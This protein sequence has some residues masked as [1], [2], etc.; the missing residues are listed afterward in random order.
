M[1]LRISGTCLVLASVPLVWRPAEAVPISFGG[2]GNALASG[3]SSV[4]GFL[5]PFS[6]DYPAPGNQDFI[7]LNQD[8]EEGDRGRNIAGEEMISNVTGS[9]GVANGQAAQEIT[10]AD[11][12]FY[13][14]LLSNTKR[15]I[16]ALENGTMVEN[17][18]Q[19]VAEAENAL[20]NLDEMPLFCPNVTKGT[21]RRVCS[22]LIDFHRSFREF[23]RADLQVP[24][25]QLD[26]IVEFQLIVAMRTLASSLAD[27]ETT[28]EEHQRNE[29]K[30]EEAIAK[31][32]EVAAATA[33]KVW[34]F[35]EQ[36]KG[37]LNVFSDLKA[38]IDEAAQGEQE[39]LVHEFAERSPRYLMRSPFMSEHRLVMD[40][41]R[42]EGNLG[43]RNLTEE[44]RNYEKQCCVFLAIADSKAREQIGCGGEFLSYF[45]ETLTVEDEE[46]NILTTINEDEVN[47][48]AQLIRG[49]E[50]LEKVVEAGDSY[51]GYI[52]HL[53]ALFDGLHSRTMWINF[54][55]LFGA[56]CL[57]VM[58]NFEEDISHMNRILKA[59]VESQR[60]L[61]K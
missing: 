57:Q 8:P 27:S 50:I 33:I 61:L 35:K 39:R 42:N 15:A 13:E 47:I 14:K 16:V 40:V 22:N 31:L 25:L 38:E 21:V 58:E 2:V 19:T 56:N 28:R 4:T 18:L 45:F 6:R 43:A 3:W 17:L 36:K 10:E 49:I 54:K 26:N 53:Q 55:K 41:W 24:N 11:Q 52:E 51:L 9:R 29:D 23:V 44:Q 5:N 60:K 46:G 37:L 30:V 32:K 59:T 20:R 7:A 1:K 48:S 34:A 12:R